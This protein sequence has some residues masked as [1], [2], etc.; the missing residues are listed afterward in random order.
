MGERVTSS[1]GQAPESTDAALQKT[2]ASQVSKSEAS[3]LDAPRP[4]STKSER[5]C[6]ESDRFP[7]ALGA[8]MA[9][10]FTSTD[11]VSLWVQHLQRMGFGQEAL[12]L[13]EGFNST[14]PGFFHDF[15]G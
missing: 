3:A 10:S 11:Q 15:M 8:L 9:R 6:S 2:D 12:A 13:A 14:R 7:L 1:E 4:S 5:E